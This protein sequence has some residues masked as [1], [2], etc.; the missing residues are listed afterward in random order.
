IVAREATDRDTAALAPDA[1]K[2]A[3]GLVAAADASEAAGQFEQAAAQ[4]RQAE[5]AF[6][7]GLVSAR[8]ASARREI[9]SEL[10][11]LRAAREAADAYRAAAVAAARAGERDVL[12]K[13]LPA[14]RAARTAAESAGAPDLAADAFSAAIR[15][16]VALEEALAAGE[17]TRVRTLLPRVGEGFAAA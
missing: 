17:L 12:E 16:Q 2:Q 5:E 11:A 15:E 1:M 3:A 4:Y 6:R 14:L 7:G 8:Q 10:P 13:E 9:E